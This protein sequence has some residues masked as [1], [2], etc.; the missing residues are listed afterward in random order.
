MLDD[1][2]FSPD[3]WLIWLGRELRDRY[4]QL[5]T[6]TAFYKGNPPLPTGPEGAA[7]AYRDFQRKA[8]TNF[9]RFAVEASVH[10]MKAIGITDA[11]GKP[12]SEAWGW[13][14]A[15]RLDSK[16]KLVFRTAL[17]L[18][19]SYA[20]VGP[21][22]K[23]QRRPLITAEHPREVIV[24]HDPATGERMAA[25]KAWWDRFERKGRAVVYLPE[26]IVKYETTSSWSPLRPL[27]WGPKNW[28]LVRDPENHDLGSVPVVPFQCVREL[29]EDP[30]P[31]FAPGMDIQERINLGMLNRMTAERYSAFRQKYVTGHKFKV[32]TDSETGL[33][34]LDQD[35]RP[36]VEQ[37]FKSHP[38]AVWASTGDQVKFGEFSQ[39]DLLGYLKS[40][41]AD[42][43][44]L[45][46]LTHTPAYYYTGD[47]INVSADTVTA[48]DTNHLAKIEDYHDS[49]G[50]SWEDVIGLAGRVAD[51]STDY[52]E[53]EVR[54]KDP[55]QLNPA[56]LAD[57]ATKLKS[58]GY[59]LDVVAEDLGESPQRIKRITAGATQQ[60]MVQA[61]LAPRFQPPGEAPVFTRGQQPQEQKGRSPV[62]AE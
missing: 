8:K 48:L 45:L 43:L 52:S 55:R 27:P 30:E 40:H 61:A 41:Q 5:D 35:G 38:G 54:W 3:W 58:I 17:S 18:A 31:D 57:R 23:D 20:I 9:L 42:V 28:G 44:D 32:I 7:Q 62:P 15:N 36:Q 34:V 19:E 2:P 53:S 24:A 13:W 56:V 14:Q 21:H 26:T 1:T 46:T 12:I 47:L 25:L 6:W 29:G 4:K 33:P 10:R 11:N 50:E 22:P 37:P 51:S 39:T 59:P 60:A 49:M 16:Q